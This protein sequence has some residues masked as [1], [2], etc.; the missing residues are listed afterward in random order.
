MKVLLNALPHTKLGYLPEGCAA[1]VVNAEPAYQKKVLDGICIANKRD[2][3]Y[4]LLGSQVVATRMPRTVS[5]CI[6]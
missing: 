5:L 4:V 1:L 6:C 2:V 3:A